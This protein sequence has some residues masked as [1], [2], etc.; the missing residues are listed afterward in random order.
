M[1]RLTFFS[2]CKPEAEHLR[3]QL[4]DFIDVRCFGLAAIPETRPDHFT[5]V[6][7][8]LKD[9]VRLLEL[10]EWIKLR[11]KEAKVIFVTDTDSRV[12]TTRAFAIGASDV[13]HRPIDGRA[14]LRKYAAKL[15]PAGDEIATEKFSAPECPGAGAASDSLQGMFSSAA[16]GEPLATTTIVAAGAAV[17]SEIED[18][19]FSSWIETVRRH[20]SQTYQHCLLVTGTAVAFARHLGL[21]M[22]DRSRLSFAGM[23]H[24]IGKAHIPLAI[25]EKAGPLDRDEL[26]IMRKHPEYGLEALKSTTGLQ[27]DMIDMVVHHHEYLDGS[28]YPHGLQASEI[29]DLVRIMTISD[30]FGAL[31]ERRS[32]KPPLPSLKAY[33]V[34]T[35]MGPKLDKDLVREFRAVS[36]MAA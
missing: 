29:S 11:P 15:A 30:I 28:G 35:D 36:Q 31:I 25:L 26:A 21:S 20:H 33:E 18:K 10:K 24:D 19:G 3:R 14:L 32:Y 27:P 23:L 8:C 1:N 17:V 4:A 34:L 7:I 13:V 12:E 6:A 16:L 2:D 5:L 9:T 22:A